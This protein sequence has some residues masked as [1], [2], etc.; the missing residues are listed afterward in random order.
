MKK[1]IFSN[2]ASGLI[3]IGIS[4]A[5]FADFNPYFDI[6]GFATLGASMTNATN[7]DFYDPLTKLKTSEVPTIYN[8]GQTPIFNQ[9]TSGGLQ[10]TAG[11]N[12]TVSF[13]VQFLTQGSEGYSVNTDWLY[14]KWVIDENWDIKIGR[15][16]LPFFLYS[17]YY[18]IG[19]DYIWSRPPVEVYGLD[20]LTDFEG[21]DLR[22]RKALPYGWRTDDMLSVGNTTL[23]IN[24][25]GTIIPYTIDRGIVANLTL[26][27]E[28]LKLSGGFAAGAIGINV[29]TEFSVV[30]TALLNPCAFFQPLVPA[31]ITEAAGPVPGTCRMTIHSPLPVPA[32]FGIAK[33]DQATAKLFNIQNVSTQ[34]YTAG[35]EFNWNHL[36][37][38]AEWTRTNTTDPFIPSSQA[39]YVLLGFTWDNLTPSITYSDYRT[40]DN[41]DRI[42]ANTVA[43][44]FVNPYSYFAPLTP[45]PTPE[46]FQTSVNEFLALS[47][48]AQ[49]TIDVGVRYDILP[50][51]AIKFDYRYV[52]PREGT[53][54][55]FDIAPG[56]R[57][58]WVTAVINVVF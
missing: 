44:T 3:L 33:P 31:E 34:L 39:W 5:S 21:I 25:A 1:R 12:D 50:A 38:I 51:T 42:L 24:Q 22:Y 41:D 27:N 40:L 30:Q 55:F 52:I 8:I 45:V 19:Y 35:Y 43:G 37:S 2:C 53:A 15:M 48:S 26:S 29:P 18:E 14:A 36:I 13:V 32:G 6:S 54:G 10:F 17:E 4:N 58:S 16:R 9:D 56:K 57:I 28:I 20:S 47:N 23:F 49:S 11:I 46:T 7:V